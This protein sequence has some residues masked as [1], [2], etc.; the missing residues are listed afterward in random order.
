MRSS[1]GIDIALLSWHSKSIT[2]RGTP[3]IDYTRRD[4]EFTILYSLDDCLLKISEELDDCF[5][6]KNKQSMNL[7][8]TFRT[9][10]ET[11]RKWAREYRLIALPEPETTAKGSNAAADARQ[12]NNLA[13]RSLVEKSKS[14]SEAAIDDVVNAFSKRKIEPQPIPCGLL[15][16]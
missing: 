6:P 5:D 3:M 4:I 13:G 1:Y 2:E 9:L 12:E 8:K 7:L 15:A 10:I 14:L 11:R 16:G